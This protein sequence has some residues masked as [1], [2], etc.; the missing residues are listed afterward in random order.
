M[1]EKIRRSLR[2]SFFDGAFYAIMFGLGDTFFTP[3]AI[4]LNATH[5][6]VGLLTSLPG[7]AAA[8]FQL[9]APALTD[10][11]GRKRFI[12]A[13]VFLQALLY[14]PI[15]AAPFLCAADPLP[16]LIAAVSVY[17]LCNAAV[18][19]AWGSMM[20][21]YLPRQS[22]GKYFSWRQ[23]VMG[24]ITLAAAAA[25]GTVLYLFPRDS[26]TGFIIIFAA[27]MAARFVSGACITG[28][29]EPRLVVTPATAFTFWEFVSR[30]RHSNFAKFVFF[31][32]FMSC[33]VNVA[34]PFFSVYMLSGLQFSYPM[35]VAITITPNL[36]MLASLRA[37]GAYT[38]KAGCIRVIQFTTLILPILPILWLFSAAVWYLLLI[39]ILS[40]VA[41]G[42]FNLAA[43][44]FI[45]DAVSEAKRV[46]AIAYFNLINGLGVFFGAALGGILAGRLPPIGGTSILTIFL[47]SGL[48]RYGVRFALLPQIREVRPVMPVTN[49]EILAGL[50]RID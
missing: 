23:R 40:G 46:R 49:R 5:F 44:N 4:A 38:D 3:F 19:P 24:F 14:L 7:L 25:G 20:T 27:A 47:L 35:Y 13:G 42:G 33:A 11:L 48:L 1:K 17:T 36:A 32:G 15:I 9:P 29:H 8:L 12:L 34:V 28:M 26:I 41:W 31:T 21:Q 2:V 39:Q 16:C 30:V 43:S 45:Y 6:Q 50:I 10:H 22:R 37:W 18:A